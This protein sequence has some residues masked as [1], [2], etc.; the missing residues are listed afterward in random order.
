MKKLISIDLDGTLLNHQS[1]ISN[2]SKKTIQ[3]LIELGHIVILATGRPLSGTIDFYKELK[4]NTPL[5]TDNGGFINHPKDSNFPVKQSFIPKNIMHEL[6]NYSKDFV[7][8]SF[9]CYNDITYAYQYHPWIEDHFSGVYKDRIIHGDLTSFDLE[10]SG[11]IYFILR[12]KQK[13]FETY[14]EN[15]LNDHLLYRTW[16]ADQKTAVYEVYLNSVSKSSAIR[17]VLDYYQIDQKD[18]ISFGDAI[19]D[20]EMIQ[21]ANLGV[22]MKNGDPLVKEVAKDMTLYTNDEDGVAKYLISY[23]NL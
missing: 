6:F 13:E 3:Q 17:Y 16:G 9:F 4:L 12:E 20:L 15:Q 11:L 21:D 8:S 18:W 19:N 5:I 2:L 14:I 23:F 22:A 10:P 1:Q 7:T